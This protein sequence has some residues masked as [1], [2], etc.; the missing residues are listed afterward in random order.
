V[1]EDDQSSPTGSLAA[2][3]QLMSQGVYAIERFSPY[4]FGGYK[5]SSSIPTTGGGFDGPEWATALNMFSTTGDSNGRTSNNT[6]NANFFKLVGATN[7]GGLAYGV[8]PSSTGSIQ[9]TKTALQ[10]I[11]LKMGYENLSVPFGGVD[12]TAYVLA[13]KQAGVNGAACSCVQSTNLAM[14]TGLRQA[15][16]TNVKSLAYASADSSVFSN[17]TAAAASQ[18]AYFPSQ[19]PPLDQNNPATNTMVANLKQYDPL[20]KGGYPSF[21][22]TG[23]YLAAA[24]MVKGLQEAG[25]NPTR[26]SFITNMRTVA[27]WDANGLFASPV[28]FNKPGT[29]QPTR[30]EWFV[31]VKG[32]TFVSNTVN[33]GKPV[34]GTS[35]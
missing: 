12:V 14:F 35:F 17:A 24:L 15:G 18:G 9:D 16:L 31:Q 34:C 33:G 7:V 32:N 20:Y 23:A 1:V 28:S 3:Q 21:G 29:S 19:F 22:A 5:A 30:C 4:D 11:G 10:M 13:M 25:Q 2:T 26:Q 8:S 27:S 6:V